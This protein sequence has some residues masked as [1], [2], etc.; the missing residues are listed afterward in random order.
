MLD[1]HPKSSKA[2]AIKTLGA[3]NHLGCR[4]VKEVPPALAP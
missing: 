1:L 2:R 3:I 4:M